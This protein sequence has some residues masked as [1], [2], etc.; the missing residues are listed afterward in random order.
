LF[1]ALE[2][3]LARGRLDDSVGAPV[4]ETIPTGVSG[5]KCNRVNMRRTPVRSC[6]RAFRMLINTRECRLLM[7]QTKFFIRPRA[8]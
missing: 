3:L 2:T 5:G 6:E 1:A 7:R 8:T 4:A